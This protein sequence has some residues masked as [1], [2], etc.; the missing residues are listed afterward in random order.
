MDASVILKDAIRNL[1]FPPLPFHM[2]SLESGLEVVKQTLS[3]TLLVKLYR[4]ENLSSVFLP[5]FYLHASQGWSR[6]IPIL[7][8]CL[9]LL[10]S[11]AKDTNV[12]YT[13]LHVSI[14]CVELKNPSAIEP[15]SSNC[16]L[17]TSSLGITWDLL[18]NA[19]SQ[20]DILK[21]WIR[22]SNGASSLGDSYAD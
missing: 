17:Q 1:V 6:R 18:R 4:R 2:S 16:G 5:L 7:L 21:R 19:G 15:H 8:I 9:N 3:L 22:I 20:S 14:T 11:G 13:S 12:E 10:A